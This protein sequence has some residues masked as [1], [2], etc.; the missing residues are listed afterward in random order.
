MDP[1]AFIQSMTF[2]NWLALVLVI[3]ALL[4][5]LNAFFS[6]KSR[7]LDWRGT[8]NRKQFEKRTSECNPPQFRTSHK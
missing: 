1:K 2:W 5:G 3:P 8:N 6:L 7:Y 4:G